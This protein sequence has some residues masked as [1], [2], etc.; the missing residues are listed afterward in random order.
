VNQYSAGNLPSRTPIKVEKPSL[1]LRSAQRYA[2]K[3][4]RKRKNNRHTCILEGGP[5]LLLRLIHSISPESVMKS[6]ETGKQMETHRQTPVGY[7]R[8]PISHAINPVIS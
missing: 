8:M 7:A 2:K 3:H 5:I 6:V 1:M 4:T